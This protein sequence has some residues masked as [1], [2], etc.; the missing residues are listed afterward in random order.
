MK[1]PYTTLTV[2]EGSIVPSGQGSVRVPKMRAI[3]PGSTGQSA[4]LEFTYRGPT[5]ITEPLASGEIRRQ[6]GLQL[7]ARDACNIVYVMWRIEP[8]SEIV[9]QLKS[10]P[11]MHT[12]VQCGAGGYTTVKPSSAA[13]IQ[14][15]IQGSFHSLTAEIYGSQLGVYVDNTLSWIGD[16]PPEAFAFDGPVGIRS[17]N[18]SF[19]FDLYTPGA[20]S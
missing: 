19:D 3:A 13:P 4:R 17:D 5:D 10:N 16:L 18:A 15:L 11:G 12:S 9:V 14:T 7:R 1:L 6:I 20:A 8:K 2:T